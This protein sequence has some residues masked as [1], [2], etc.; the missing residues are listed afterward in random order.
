MKDNT[1]TLSD[2]EL[3]EKR[4]AQWRAYYYKYKSKNPEEN[5][6]LYRLQYAKNREARKQCQRNYNERNRERNLQRYRDN[7]EKEISRVLES[8][9]KHL[10][11]YQAYQKDYLRKYRKTHPVDKEKA[12]KYAAEYHLKNKKKKADYEKAYRKANPEAGRLKAHAR[13]A[14]MK[15]SKEESKNL[16]EWAKRLASKTWIGCY[17]CGV[18]VRFSECHL[19]HIVPLVKGGRHASD[20]LCVSCPKCNLTKG[21]QRFGEW[22]RQG[23][24]ILEL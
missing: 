9:A 18:K 15:C 11:H 1:S 14:N 3:A 13:R 16:R 8:R 6:A 7:R 17:W 23:Q 4:R 22:K 12:R 24:A 20:N 21:A 5:R 2:L 10:D 19:D